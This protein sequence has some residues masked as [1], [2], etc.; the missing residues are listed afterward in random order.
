MATQTDVQQLIQSL[1]P[2][3][4]NNGNPNTIYNAP[5]AMDAAGN[6]F[7]S[8]LPT[9]ASIRELRLAGVPLPQSSPL[10]MNTIQPVD[11][12]P[13]APG[14]WTPPDSWFP[15]Q[16][17]GTVA[18]PN[19]EVPIQN[20]TLPPNTGP[21]TSVDLGHQ[22]GAYNPSP[23]I[24]LGNGV[25]GGIGYYGGMGGGAP[26]AGSGSANY[27]AS[28][29]W[30]SN[31]GLAGLLGLD[32]SG[33]MSW[34]QLLDILSEPLISGD[35][36]NPMTKTWNLGNLAGGI[37]GGPANLINN[38]FN[39]GLNPNLIQEQLATALHKGQ[40]KML[41]SIGKDSAALISESVR[42][43]M[44]KFGLQ[45][46]GQAAWQPSTV[47]QAFGAGYDARQIND[48]IASGALGGTQ[49]GAQSI[50]ASNNPYFGIIEGDA[51][52]AMMEG[53][54]SR[55][56]GVTYGVNDGTAFYNYID[57]M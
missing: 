7:A 3:G 2:S 12:R 25:M 34:Q 56:G 11:T 54:S 29:L 13:L 43:I 33:R 37:I 52:R 21:I 19:T 44:E 24:P 17:P 38:L 35:L 5:P 40:S 46:P 16:P 41:N 4:V 55:G 45:D 50:A 14:P 23:D 57:M 48:M 49:F 6:W 8:A 9:A 28:G 31:P 30:G 36:Y 53:M 15:V 18:P 1:V 10:P 27:G 47:G 22:S 51:A 20:P 32:Q 26:A 42:D 39:T